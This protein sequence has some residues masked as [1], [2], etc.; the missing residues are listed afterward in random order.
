MRLHYSLSSS[1]GSVFGT[2]E[3]FGTPVELRL[4]LKSGGSLI[5][6]AEE[7]LLTMSEGERSRFVFLP[8]VAYKSSADWE[9]NAP[10]P[11]DLPFLAELHLV[12]IV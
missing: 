9:A 10:I 5:P 6:G 12:K 8:P 11:S 2:T 4:G 7:A 3:A 1:N